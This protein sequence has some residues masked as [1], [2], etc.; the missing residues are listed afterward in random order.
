MTPSTYMYA[1]AIRL[2]VLISN[3]RQICTMA[4][5]SLVFLVLLHTSPS[6]YFRTQ[7]KIF[8][9]DSRINYQSSGIP[10]PEWLAQFTL[11]FAPFAA[12]VFTGIPNIV[13]ANHKEPSSWHYIN[14]Y[15]PLT[16]VWRYIMITDRRIRSVHWTP[17]D[18]SASNAVFWTGN[19]KWD[20]SEEIMVT[21]R[22]W[23]TQRP[24]RNRVSFL[25][26]SM[27]GTLIITLQGIQALYQLFQ[28]I[29]T[30][31]TPI[32]ALADIFI[33]LGV[34][35]LF[36]LPAALW[37]ISEF[38]YDGWDHESDTMELTQRPSS[39]VSADHS[40]APKEVGT[41]S[42]NDINLLST[43]STTYRS[44][45]YSM[46]SSR[47][48]H[49]K[50]NIQHNNANRTTQAARIETNLRPQTFWKATLFRITFIFLMLC[51]VFIF[52]LGHLLA[53]KDN[54]TNVSLLLGHF[55]YISLCATL[56]ILSPYYFFRKMGSSTMIPCI[57]STWYTIYTIVWYVYAG[58]CIIFNCIEMRRTSCGVYTT[59]PPSAGLDDRLCSLYEN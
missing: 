54:P 12:H 28:I 13:I 31:L 47:P 53:Q 50:I 42:A 21:S 17:E 4:S 35:S 22:A 11:C 39:G 8:E 24:L 38:G 5:I 10:L 34:A 3:M 1:S 32:Q 45:S 7:H 15:N 25:S 44:E 55:L 36:R 30:K 20:S 18:L 40:V 52:G 57:N 49:A 58:V 23:I 9:R 37:L 2:R 16:I 19:N 46:D 27:L 26:V 41:F 59:F 56:L 6:L 14:F 48:L 51:I 33:P 43:S 29:W